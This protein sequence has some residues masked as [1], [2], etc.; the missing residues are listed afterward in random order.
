MKIDA[1][2]VRRLLAYDPTTGRFFNAVNRRR[3][4]K[5]APAEIEH[6]AGYRCVS[7]GGQKHLSHRLVW[8]YLHGEWPSG[9]IDH[10]DGD[11]QNN[12]P[13]NLRDVPR[14]VNTQNV[15]SARAN[16][17]S[18]LLGATFCRQTGRWASTIRINGV[19]THIGRFDTA[20]QAHAA[21]MRAKQ[22]HHI[23]YVTCT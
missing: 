8:L 2:E 21:Y 10:I 1:D 23:G 16:N 20:E 4:R 13:S 11:K 15:R 17:A 12:R 18:G 19:K 3:A 9:D 5:G 6:N 14:M 7:I 22:Q